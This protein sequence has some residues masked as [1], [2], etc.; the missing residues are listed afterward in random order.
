[1]VGPFKSVKGTVTLALQALRVL[2]KVQPS[3]VN[4]IN[5]VNISR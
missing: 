5:S 3:M 2:Q 1:M 4:L